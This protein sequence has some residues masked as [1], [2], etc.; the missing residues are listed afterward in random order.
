MYRKKRLAEQ[1]ARPCIAVVERSATEQET[2]ADKLLLLWL[3]LRNTF[4]AEQGG[5]RFPERAV[6]TTMIRAPTEGAWRRTM[7]KHGFTNWLAVLA[8]L[9]MIGG[10]A[11]CPP[12]L[13]VTLNGND[14]KVSQNTD[15]KT[16]EGATVKH[17]GWTLQ[18]LTYVPPITTTMPATAAK[19]CDLCD[20]QWILP[21]AVSGS[22]LW[23]VFN[24]E[25]AP[26]ETDPLPLDENHES[27]T[28]TYAN[29]DQRIEITLNNP[30]FVPSSGEGEGE[31]EGPVN[32]DGGE[33]RVE[34]DPQGSGDKLFGIGMGDGKNIPLSCLFASAG[35]I[36]GKRVDFPAGD[37]G[38]VLGAYIYVAG[39]DKILLEPK[40]V[41]DIRGGEAKWNLTRG[42]FKDE[43]I[44]S[45]FQIGFWVFNPD[46]PDKTDPKNNKLGLWW[47]KN[48]SFGS[49]TPDTIEF[50]GKGLWTVTID[51]GTP[52]T[53]NAPVITLSGSSTITITVGGVYTDPG[54]TATDGNGNTVNVTISGSVNTSI[55]GTYTITYTAT[56][57]GK[58]T[59][60]TRTIVVTP[61][62]TTNYTLSVSINPTGAGSVTL[63]PP[64]G[65]YASGT[66]VTATAV[67]NNGYAFTGWSGDLGGTSSSNTIVMT[68][69]KS[70][71]A[72]FVSSGTISGTAMTVVNTTATLYPDK[73]VWVLDGGASVTEKPTQ[74]GFMRW[75]ET[76]DGYASG[77]SAPAPAFAPY[78]T[79]VTVTDANVFET[80]KTT[81][82]GNHVFIRG[83]IVGKLANGTMVYASW[84]VGQTG[85]CTYN[86]A[87]FPVVDNALKV[88][89]R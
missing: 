58:T 88:Q 50:D 56:F 12:P 75:Y 21:I 46:H 53:T 2:V 26:A 71:I 33:V 25:T 64:G 83:T 86:G 52:P 42:V 8:V 65:S 36:D 14:F 37:D 81:T 10:L 51:D 31:G 45:S 13:V 70:A 60:S 49:S 82:S 44:P 5:R 22:A 48:E 1:S 28:A 54:A 7:K 23:A 66:S 24:F 34:S 16:C 59:T 84:G 77:M 73:I 29:G 78:A 63:S 30:C 79:T 43:P 19:T 11:G 35:K 3:P 68:A 32:C 38:T 6:T 85:T 41:S 15:F 80:T 87:S 67:A 89:V 74:V 57:N 9:A 18:E 40:I 47:A 62:A 4:V 69:N 72:Q 39:R 61:A 27:V 76:A 17:D 55:A 20:L